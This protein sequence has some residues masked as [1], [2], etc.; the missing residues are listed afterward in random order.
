MAAPAAGAWCSWEGKVLRLEIRVQPRASRN[1]AAGIHG[2]RLRL[3][4]TSP[5][6]ENRANSHLAA[7]IAEEFH[8]APGRVLLIRGAHSRN[9]TVRIDAPGRLPAWFRELHAAATAP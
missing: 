7:W 2:G 3:R 8:V 4:L 1:E 6:V 9:K 5:A